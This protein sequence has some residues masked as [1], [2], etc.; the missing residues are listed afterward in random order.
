MRPSA[1]FAWTP[2]P[3]L[4]EDSTSCP[5]TAVPYLREPWYCWAEPRR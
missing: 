4:R 5:R 2:D 1:A 3:W